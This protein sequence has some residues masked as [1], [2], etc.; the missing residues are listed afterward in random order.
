MSFAIKVAALVLM[1]VCRW[2]FPRN[3][4]IANII[5]TRYGANAVMLIRKFEKLD[6]RYR[7]LLLDIE[8]LNSCLQDGLIPKFLR[9]RMANRRTRPYNYTKYQK[10]MLQDELTVKQSSLSSVKSQLLSTKCTLNTIFSYLDFSHV[11]TVFLCG[12]D[13]RLNNIQ[14]THDRKLFTL[15]KEGEV[16]KIDYSKV[17]HNFSSVELSDFDKLVL[18]KGLNFAI[19]P[20]K[21]NYAD[22]CLNFEI[23]FRDIMKLDM[24]NNAN[25]DFI[26]TKLKEAALSSFEN[27]NNDHTSHNNLSKDEF[28]SLEALASN[29]DL[30]IQK[31]DKG[32]AIVLLD[33]NVYIN[34]M[35]DILKDNSKF[36]LLSPGVI[37]PGKELQ[38]IDKE[39]DKVRSFL[40]K[41]HQYGK[42]SKATFNSLYPIGS[43]PGVL[44]GLAK[45][46][47]ALADGFPKF[48]PILSTI[49]TCSYNLAKF[50]VPMLKDITENE[51]SIKNTFDFGKEVLQQDASLFMGSLDVEALFTSLPL[52]ETIDIAVNEL[53]K[54]TNVVNNLNKSEFKSLLEFSTKEPWFIFDQKFYHQKDGVSMGSPLGPTLANIFMAFYETKWLDQCPPEF[55]PVFYR[56]YIDDIFV[57]FRS[58]EHLKEFETYFNSC[59][60]N[61]SF[62]SEKEENNCMPFLDFEFCRSHNLITSTVYRKPTF[63]GVYT[64]FESLIHFSYKKGLILTLL[65]RIFHI[66]S[67]HENMIAEVN[68][69]KCILQK[70]GYPVSIID[71]CIRK[72]FL[73]VYNVKE[74]IPTCNKKQ[75]WLVLPYLGKQSLDLKHNLEKLFHKKL[76][77]CYNVRIIFKTNK[78]ISHFFTFKDKIPK[79]L[80][81]HQVYQFKCSGCNSCYVG[82]SERHTIVRWFD[83]LGLSWRTGGKIVGVE[84]EI[85]QHLRECKSTCS[86][87]NFKVI[88]QDNKT[89]NLRIKE[90]LFIK[91]D[92]PNLNKNV[93]STPLYL[94]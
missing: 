67:S 82:L 64:H 62:T 40:K 21:L 28:D 73:K 25:E 88:G 33:K 89:M 80:M 90:S 65:H 38:F 86:I 5:R 23:L 91:R 70:N 63:T 60:S 49:G 61:I 76:P 68:K 1:V 29:R 14:V 37:K 18:G 53:F 55:K 58:P 84:T 32:N 9:F 87:D 39:E 20:K 78:R 54:D 66:C 11:C 94:F 16:I 85:K 42:I 83:H 27:F 47:K 93:F 81:S 22:Y 10:L 57:M 56:R 34:R 74:K 35:L 52:N 72:F 48:R 15:R 3:K 2:R 92:K 17:I 44:Y 59:H 50:C 36:E 7:K 45:V 8:F 13:N 41:L 31:S 26:K 77:F 19:S 51:F 71:R 4:S 6:F 69:L 12:N 46:H 43:R 75:L 79:Q 30:I 24:N